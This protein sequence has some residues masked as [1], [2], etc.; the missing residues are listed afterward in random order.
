MVRPCGHVLRIKVELFL[1]IPASL[2]HRLNKKALRGRSVRVDGA[3]WPKAYTYCE[4]CG[5][6]VS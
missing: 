1:D 3:N 6:R 2:S 4:K 5:M